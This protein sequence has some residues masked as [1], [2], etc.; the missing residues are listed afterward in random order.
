MEPQL[1]MAAGGHK[2][3]AHKLIHAGKDVRMPERGATAV[4]EGPILTHLPF[5]PRSRSH[6]GPAG[7]RYLPVPVLV[8]P[9]PVDEEAAEVLA[10]FAGVYMRNEHILQA[11]VKALV[12]RGV[13]EEEERPEAQGD[14]GTKNKEQDKFF[15]E[16]QGSPV[17]REGGGPQVQGGQPPPGERQQGGSGHPSANDHPAG[18]AS[19]PQQPSPGPAPARFGHLP[20]RRGG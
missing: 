5:H 4:R 2:A 13:G 20:A 15:G 6:G 17:V 19:A 18:P 14:E 3:S 8:V 11:Q 12:L 16:S 1:H 10:P 7:R 9:L